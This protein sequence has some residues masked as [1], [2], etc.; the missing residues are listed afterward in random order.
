MPPLR[1]RREDIPE[2]AEYFIAQGGARDGRQDHRAQPRG[3]IAKL[4]AYDGPATFASW[5]IR[6][7]RAAL[8][9]PGN[10]IRPEDIELEHRPSGQR[11]SADRTKAPRWAI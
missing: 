1:E 3:A 7:M 4:R 6:V 9:A 10:T 2:L 11:R 8:L 5:K